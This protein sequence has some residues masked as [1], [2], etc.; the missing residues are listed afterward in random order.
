MPK[1]SDKRQHA[2]EAG[3]SYLAKHIHIYTDML[4]LQTHTHTQN[5]GGT[6]VGLNMLAAERVLQELPEGN[7][8]APSSCFPRGASGAQ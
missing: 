3:W 5:C 7:L 8:F 6:S 2:P 4:A 1:R